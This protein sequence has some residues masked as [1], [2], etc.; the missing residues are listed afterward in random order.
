MVEEVGEVVGKLVG[1]AVCFGFYR[2]GEVIFDLF[3]GIGLL[4]FVV[5]LWLLG[6]GGLWFIFLVKL[7][8]FALG[9]TLAPTLTPTW[10]PP[11]TLFWLSSPKIILLRSNTGALVNFLNKGLL[12]LFYKLF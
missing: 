5:M 8:W 2:I 4:G 7:T 12:S 6:K 11:P 1:G 9:P 3:G 10:P